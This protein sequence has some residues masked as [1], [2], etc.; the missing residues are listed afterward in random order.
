MLVAVIMASVTNQAG[1]VLSNE[2]F[3][4][5]QQAARAP[6]QPAMVY[7]V[8]AGDSLWAIAQRFQV[9][10]DVLMTQNGL[11]ENSLLGIGQK[12]TIPGNGYRSHRI[13][14]GE[15]L[16]DI[17]RA[18][19]TSVEQL[20][21]LNPDLEANSLVIGE[22]ITLPGGSGRMAMSQVSRGL[23]YR[24]IL[25]WPIIGQITSYFGWRRPGYHY[26]LDIAGKSGD[27]IQAAAAGVVAF[28]GWKGNYGKA[29]VIEHGDGRQTLYGHMQRTL[30][31]VGESVTRGEII[32]RVGSTGH[33]TG[34]HVH[35]EVRE[36]G[37]CYNPL[38]FLR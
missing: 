21:K 18:N 6:G 3:S 26:G 1:A 22:V 29:V 17:A 19:G 31:R 38:K 28:A 33:S 9:N 24:M 16:W 30:V 37:I 32:G 4:P 34:P 5:R 12:I 15:T 11:A 20:Q 13:G 8:A 14:A 23:N 25:N 7:Y 36:E 35:F 2:D 27:P 10:L